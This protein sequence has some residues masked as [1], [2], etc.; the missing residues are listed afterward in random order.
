MKEKINGY[1]KEKRKEAIIKFLRK[2]LVG[3]IILVLVLIVL[4]ALKL[5]KKQLKL[6][7]SLAIEDAVGKKKGY[8]DD[9]F[10]DDIEPL[11]D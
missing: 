11:V 6:G 3:E 10:D 9:G 5:F 8:E 7:L 1:V 2:H 4:V